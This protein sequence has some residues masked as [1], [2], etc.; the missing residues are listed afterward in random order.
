[1]VK[2]S[3]QQPVAGLKSEKEK[4][5][6]AG[7]YGAKSETLLPQDAEAQPLPLLVQNRRPFSRIFY[8]TMILMSLLLGLVLTSIYI[9]RYF[10]VPSVSY[11]F[12]DDDFEEEFRCGVVYFGDFNEPLELYE[13]VKI[14]LEENYERINVPL[15]DSGESDPADIIHDFHRGLTAYHDVAVDKCY[16][17]EL[18]TTIV[19]TPQSFGE[20]LVNEKK[21]TDL[22]QTYIIQEELTVTEQVTDLGQ[23]GTSIYHLC[24]DKETY[25]VKRSTTRR[26][27]RRRAAEKCHHIRHF[28]NT[29]VVD[30]A[31]CPMF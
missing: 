27:I 21:G 12:E 1:M 11:A 23:F 30:T 19:M 26:Y 29:F 2:I 31:I 14:H 4:A 16:I 7:N 28:E 6:A 13:S 22:P 5:V 17:T 3:F 8:L 25:W 20:L 18:N 10:S 24:S 15:S 9:Y